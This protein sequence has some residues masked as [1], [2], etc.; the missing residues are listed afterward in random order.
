MVSGLMAQSHWQGQQAPFPL[1][2]NDL[3]LI[4][5]LLDIQSRATVQTAT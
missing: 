5:S 4:C 1:L 3:R 2:S